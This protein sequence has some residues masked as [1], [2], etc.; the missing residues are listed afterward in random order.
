MPKTI[1]IVD[2]FH[3][4]VALLEKKL[5]SEGFATLAAYDGETAIR[6]A[7][8]E[9]PD[10]VLLDIM[11]PNIGGTE[12]RVELMKE[13]DTKAIPVLFLTGLRAPRF[14]KASPSGV[15]VIGKSNDFNDLLAAI[16]EAL[17]KTVQN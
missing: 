6:L 10:L 17:A 8:S 11:M 7:R 16:R 4:Y 1:L 9:R 12:V 3:D 5:R 13:E 14:S 15:K 2:D